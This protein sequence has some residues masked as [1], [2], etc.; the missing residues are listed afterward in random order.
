MIEI[1][2]SRR[3]HVIGIIL[4]GTQILVESLRIKFYERVL[5]IKKTTVKIA[6]KCFRQRVRPMGNYSVIHN[7][8]VDLK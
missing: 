8:R 5:F 4:A 3:K 7:F 2:T 1:R 6:G